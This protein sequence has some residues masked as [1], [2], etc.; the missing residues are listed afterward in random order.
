MEIGLAHLSGRETGSALSCINSRLASARQFFLAA[1][2]ARGS[3][4]LQQAKQASYMMI[5]VFIKGINGLIGS[6][7]GIVC[8]QKVSMATFMRWF[9]MTVML[10]GHLPS[11]GDHNVDC[12]V[13]QSPAVWDLQHPDHGRRSLQV[14]AEKRSCAEMISSNSVEVLA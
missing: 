12:I 7:L 14:T 2:V 11:K 3:G 1:A 6:G 5:H 8:F 13:Q 10:S 9:T 4:A